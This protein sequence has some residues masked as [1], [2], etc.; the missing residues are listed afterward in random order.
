MPASEQIHAAVTAVEHLM[1]GA[2]ALGFGAMWK[3]GRAAYSPH[4]R[5]AIGLQ[6]TDTIVGFVYL[7]SE[8]GPP[9][10]LTRAQARNVVSWWE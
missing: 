3:T 6:A 5:A 2:K 9:S 1:L 4:V 7:G 8:D 10:P